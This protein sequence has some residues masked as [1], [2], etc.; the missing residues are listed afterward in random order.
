VADLKPLHV[1]KF[2]ADIGPDRM[3]DNSLHSILR[4]IKGAFNWACKQGLIAINPIDKIEMP[5]RTPREV[6]VTPEQWD[7]VMESMT[8]ECF[9]DLL[10]FLK[11]TGCRPFE[12]LTVTAAHFDREHKRFVL[13]RGESKGKKYNRVIYLNEPALAHRREAH[14]EGSRRSALP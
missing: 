1:T 13:S 8:D 4:T 11:E 14:P 5:R 3:T 6:T 10:V 7:K 9:R 2:R 12:A